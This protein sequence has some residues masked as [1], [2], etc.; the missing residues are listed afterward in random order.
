[1]KQ[2]IEKAY[3]TTYDDCGYGPVDYVGNYV[4][5]MLISINVIDDTPSDLAWGGE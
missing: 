1:M 3:S 2:K 5:N 4:E